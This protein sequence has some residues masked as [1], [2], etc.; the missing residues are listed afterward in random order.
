[1]D[2]VLTVAEARVLGCLIEKE[3]GTPEYYPL[4]LNALVNACNQ[5]SNREPLMQLDEPSVLYALD[6]LRDKR[7]ACRMDMA[8]SRTPK[9]QHRLGQVFNFNE[10]ESALL[11]ELLVRGPQTL[12]ELRTHAMRLREF[13][14]MEEVEAA[15][16]HLA[17]RPEGPF[18]LRL[19]RWPGQK[20][21]RY[22]HLLCG[23]VDASAPPAPEPAPVAA[24]RGAALESRVAALEQD[25]AALRARLEDLARQWQ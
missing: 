11:C 10:F 12:G 7:L 9:F 6:A 8:G 13:A 21:P 15:L 24:D 4:S 20:E 16:D 25:V 17:T 1:M 19:P 5:K 2:F 22:A 14:R 3:L 18:V 23:P